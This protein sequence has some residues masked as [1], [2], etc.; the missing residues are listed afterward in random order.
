MTEEGG[1][2]LEEDR[3]GL[4]VRRIGE[5]GGL[6]AIEESGLEIYVGFSAE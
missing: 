5:N 4:G 2:E 6:E 1:V 3:L